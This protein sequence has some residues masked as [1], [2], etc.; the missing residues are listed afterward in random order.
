MSGTGPAP[1]YP[2]RVARRLATHHDL[3]IYYEGHSEA[4]PTR[5]PDISPQGM[6]INTPRH[7]AE[8]TVL[9]VKFRLDRS[10]YEVQARAEVRYCLDGVG[11]GIEFTDI[12]DEAREAI[13]AELHDDY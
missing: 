3:E 6:F 8:G 13:R 7:F 5:V 4:V 9:K 10:N 1:G 11:I 12:A 2:V